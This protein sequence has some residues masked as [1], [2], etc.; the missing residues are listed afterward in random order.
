MLTNIARILSAGRAVLAATIITALSTTAAA[1]TTVIHYVFQG[2]SATAIVFE[3]TPDGCIGTATSA[4]LIDNAGSGGAV[5][6]INAERFNY[7]T[8]P[9]YIYNVVAQV[10]LSRDQFTFDR[11][12]GSATLKVSVPA[13]DLVS[14]VIVN[15]N[16]DLTWTAI[17]AGEVTRELLTTV[18]PDGTRF[19]YR[20]FGT[21]RRATVYGS[22]SDATSLVT[23]DFTLPAT[24]VTI[25]DVKSGTLILTR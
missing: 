16:V 20:V 14:D 22:I 19:V 11:K 8:G 6:F 5:A 13:Q 1:R 23:A 18:S 17:E 24:D 3:V 7:C 25:E 9:F 12:L 15:L 2:L 4:V 10:N 21:L